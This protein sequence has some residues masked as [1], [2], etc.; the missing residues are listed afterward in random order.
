M[1]GGWRPQPRDL[2]K[3]APNQAIPG[4]SALLGRKPQRVIDQGQ[5][6]DDT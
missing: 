5:P 6:V 3:S 1:K 4:C 2:S